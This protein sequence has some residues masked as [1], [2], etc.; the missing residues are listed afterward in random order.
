MTSRDRRRLFGYFFARLPDLGLGRVPDP[1]RKASV[2]HPLARMLTAC[3]AAIVTGAKGFAGV[4]HLTADLSPAARR[5]LG[6]FGRIP[7]TTLRDVLVK[8]D[9]LA[10][11][12]CLHRAVRAAVRRK[13][14]HRD[15]LPF[16][17][18]SMD[19][20]ATALS[21]WDDR[22]AQRQTHSSGRGA[23]GIVRT[24]T[25]CLISSRARPC[26]DVFPIL[27]GFNEM[28]AFQGAIEHLLAAY[29]G[30]DLFRMVT[31]DAGACSKSN[32]D[33][34]HSK[35]LLYLFCLN[36]QQP[37][38]YAEA[39]RVLGDMPLSQAV[40]VT[41]TPRDQ[42]VWRRYLFVTEELAGW[43][44]WVHLRT[45]V[46]VVSE[47]SDASGHL[48]SSEDH[49]YVS[50]LPLSRLEPSQWS[51]LVRR[52]WAVENECHNTW[53]TVFEEDAHPWVESDARGAVVVMVLR[54]LAYTLMALLRSVTLRS[55]Q[56]RSMPWRTLVHKLH[57]TLLSIADEAVAS[58]RPRRT[59]SLAV[60]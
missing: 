13:A 1:R 44:D 18:V 45:V 6:L 32:A 52:R 49:Y 53:D 33:F 31:Y 43:L 47:R 37:T 7:D 17:V 25:S 39:K 4:E 27:A 9:P 8:L 24:V 22:F 26:I 59:T 58:L 15:G 57:V 36:E 20:K 41:E 50:N 40:H 51:E 5:G 28:S 56:S 29:K 46:R 34:V 55:E 14:I 10:L 16:G 12:G 42:G 23:V 11:V 60:P 2:R 30:L 19:G 35:G 48:V 38:L 54:R 3:L 21:S